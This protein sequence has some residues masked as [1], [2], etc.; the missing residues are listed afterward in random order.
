MMGNPV[1]ETMWGPSE[2]VPNG[3][4]LGWDRRAD[5]PGIRVPALVLAGRYGETVPECAETIA[6]GLPDARLVV[7]EES[8]H[9]PHLEEPTRWFPEVARFLAERDA[10]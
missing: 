8:A 2:L 10:G 9:L 6:R 3:T 5:L 7:F 1:Y 4:L